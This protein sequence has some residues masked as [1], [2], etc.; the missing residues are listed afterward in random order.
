MW[1]F[2]SNKFK[3][4]E[5]FVKGEDSTVYLASKNAA[6]RISQQKKSIKIIINLRNPTKR[7][8]SNYNHLLRTSRAFIILRTQL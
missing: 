5:N 3:G 2:Y 6:K 7:T 4:K 1:E 8:Y